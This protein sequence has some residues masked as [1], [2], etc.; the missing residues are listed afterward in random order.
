[1]MRLLRR[2]TKKGQTGQ[3]LVILAIGFLALLGFVGIVTDVSV[4]FIRYSTMRRAVDAAAIAAAGQMRRVTDEDGNLFAEGEAMSVAN[5]NLAARQF[6]EVYGLNPQSVVVE[7]CRAQQ[8]A[9]D[10][11]GNALDGSGQRLFLDDGTQNPLVTDTALLKRYKELCTRDELKLV[12]VTAQIDAPTIF[13]RLLGYPTVTL[14]E[15]AIS[16]TAVIDV[17]MIFDVSESMLNQTSYADWDTL[18][19]QRG[20]RYIPAFI[21]YDRTDPEPVDPFGTPPDFT[22]SANDPWEYLLTNTENDLDTWTGSNDTPPSVPDARLK[23]LTLRYEVNGGAVQP[24]DSTTSARQEP[25]QFC[26]VRAYPFSSNRKA[27]I[28]Q[29]LRTEYYNFLNLTAHD[30]DPTTYSP[31]YNGEA[32]NNLDPTLNLI[33]KVYNGYP[34]GAD[35][36]APVAYYMGFVPQY[37]YYGCCNDPDGNMDFDDLICQP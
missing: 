6:I 4:L 36:P 27:E 30:S 14:T 32:E 13:L 11:D 7:T 3:S 1:M 2:I 35:D 9:R 18:S 28:P 19:P 34:V 16:Q 24:F 5:L 10:S 37:N 20:V 33:S 15:S 17:V 23:D 8:V 21:K 26:R 22:L 31:V 12:R 29:D 25:R